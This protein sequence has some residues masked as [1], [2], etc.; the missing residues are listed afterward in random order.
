MKQMLGKSKLWWRGI[1]SPYKKCKMS[2]FQFDILHLQIS[3]LKLDIPI[4][5]VIYEQYIKVFL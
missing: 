3:G 5:F 4:T 1:M 2:T